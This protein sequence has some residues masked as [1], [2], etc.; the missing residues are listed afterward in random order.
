M[1]FELCT[2]SVYDVATYIKEKADSYTIWAYNLSTFFKC[3]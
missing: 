2:E 1:N 3:V